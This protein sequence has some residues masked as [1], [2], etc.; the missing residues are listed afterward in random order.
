MDDEANLYRV[1]VRYYADIQQ[2]E[3]FELEAADL[4]EAMSRAAERC[5]DRALESADLVEVRLANPAA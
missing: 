3:I 2:Y 5:P 1:T 4:R